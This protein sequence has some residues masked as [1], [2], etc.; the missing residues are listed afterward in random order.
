MTQ[1][2]T[3]DSLSLLGDELCLGCKQAA[4]DENGGL[5]VAFG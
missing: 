1:Q 3:P 4:V 5:V 2:V